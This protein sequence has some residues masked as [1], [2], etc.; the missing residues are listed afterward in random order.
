[1]V[2]GAAVGLVRGRAGLREYTDEAVNDPDVRHVRER[3]TRAADD[4]EVTEDGV[5]VEVELTDGRV[6]AK[7]LEGSLGNLQRP[8]SDEQ[9]DAKFRDQATL[10]LPQVQAERA[11]AL[12]R[13]AD[14]LADVRE[15]VDATIPA[16]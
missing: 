6:L 3:T 11:L 8:L 4:P 14:E 2:H 9:L 12:C 7:R 13:R 5:R 15:L 16:G 10:A 1:V